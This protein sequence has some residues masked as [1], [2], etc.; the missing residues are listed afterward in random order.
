MCSQELVYFCLITHFCLPC[1]QELV[2]F[3]LITLFYFIAAI[4]SAVKAG[5]FASAGAACVSLF[6]SS[7]RAVVMF[8]YA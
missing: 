1:L 6:A 7:P 2:Y 8:V 5:V 4:I 3:C